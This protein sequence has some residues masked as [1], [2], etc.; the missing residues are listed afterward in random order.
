MLKRIIN[1]LLAGIMIAIGGSVFL[2]LYAE[3]RIVGAIFFAVALLTI[4]FGKFS[5][6]TGA[7]GYIPRNHK[8]DDF[9]ALLLGLLGNAAGTIIC[10]LL[11]KIASPSICNTATVICSAKLLQN[12]PMT[13]IRAFFCGILMYVAVSMFREHKTTLGIFFCIPVF[14]L[15]GFEHS[16]ANMFYFAASDIVSL[17]AFG[18]ICLCILGNAIGGMLFP[19]LTMLGEIGNADKK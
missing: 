14:I 19:L 4:C 5:L 1:G 6:F 18:Y 8:K 11:M 2:S 16:I 9:S 15:S 10:G 3:S 17:E 12:I 13:L 7:I